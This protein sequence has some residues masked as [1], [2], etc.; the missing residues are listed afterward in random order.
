MRNDEVIETKFLLHRVT[1][2]S[3]RNY[4]LIAENAIG[5]TTTHL[6]LTQS[7][8]QRGL[9]TKIGSILLILLW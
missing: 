9:Y 4:T 3:F 5:R 8:N 2:L 6:E 7:K 1:Q